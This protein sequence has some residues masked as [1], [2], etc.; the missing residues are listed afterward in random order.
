MQGSRHGQSSVVEVLGCVQVN[1]AVK[2]TINEP[3]SQNMVSLYSYSCISGGAEDQVRVALN[4]TR[5][6]NG[7]SLLFVPSS[8]TAVLTVNRTPTY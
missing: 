7:K 5:N 2:V 4:V 8:G 6:G 3:T 1:S